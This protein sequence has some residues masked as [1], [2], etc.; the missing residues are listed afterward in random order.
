MEVFIVSASRTPIGKYGRSLSSVPA[1]K[2]G[3]AAVKDALLRAKLETKDVNEVIVGNAIEAGLGQNPARQVAVESGFSYDI[4]AFTVNMVCG[5]SLKAAMLAVQSIRAGDSRIVVAAGIESMSGAP[6]FVRGARFGLKYNNTI[7]Y[8]AM[9][10][11]GLWDAFYDVHMI[12]TGEVI[13]RKYGLTR[14]EIDEFAYESHMK[15]HAAS[16]GG[17]FRREIVPIQT[18]GGMIDTD[19]CIRPDT[20]I[21]RLSKLQPVLPGGSFVT[22][23]NA[24]QLS[25]GGSAAVLAAEEEVKKR[26][27]EPMAKVITY[28]TVGVDPFYVMEAPIPGVKQLL[29]RAGMSLSKIGLFEHNEAYA[30]A[31][32]AVRKALGIEPDRFNIHGGAVALGHPL[33]ASGVRVLTTLLYNLRERNEKYGVAT[34][35]LGG[36]NAVSMLIE[37]MMV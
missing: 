36:G 26:R 11:D 5:S 28:N 20:T 22:A 7:F 13:A 24:S 18:E 6:Y 34:I 33:G 19:E 30:S 1:K 17:R 2:L 21:E 35:C 27:L 31:S 16:A 29:E 15:A 23:G 8:D 9:V 10:N 25:D 14:E 4:A 3:A 32:V 12:Q 37:N